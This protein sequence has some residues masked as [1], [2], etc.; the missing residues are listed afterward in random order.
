MPSFDV[1]SEVNHQ[2]LDNAINQARKEVETR[3]DLRD[4]NTEIHLEKDHIMLQCKDE[5][6]LKAVYDIIVAKLVRRNVDPKVLEQGKIEPASGASVRCKLSL[7]EG[8][9]QDIA[10]SMIKSIKETKLKVQGQI[11]GD[12]CW[13]FS[14]L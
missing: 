2:E 5:Y 1:V 3:Y 11:Q 14:A 13:I 7:K 10:K 12:Q 9:D 8:I 6:T 4:S